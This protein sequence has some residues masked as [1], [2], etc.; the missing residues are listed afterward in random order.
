MNFYTA[1]S[2]KQ[3]STGRHVAPVGLLF[4]LMQ[5][6]GEAADSYV[7]SFSIEIPSNHHR[8]GFIATH[9]HTHMIRVMVFNVSVHLGS[10][11]MFGWVRV[12][13]LLSFLCY[14]FCFCFVCLRP[15]SCMSNVASVSGSPL[16]FFLT[17]FFKCIIVDIF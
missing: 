4:V 7:N 11:P 13:H 15:V 1:I 10:P 12:A 14:V 5:P 3:Q 16:R 17:F 6:I 2:L 8:G 9:T